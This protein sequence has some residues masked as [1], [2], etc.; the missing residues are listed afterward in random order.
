M[1]IIALFCLGLLGLIRHSELRREQRPMLSAMFGAVAAA[2]F[3]A[4]AASVIYGLIRV[5]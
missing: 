1:G 5:E 3:A 2:S 4:A